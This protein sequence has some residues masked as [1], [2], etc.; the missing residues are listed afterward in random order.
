MNP[1]NIRIK[2]I[3]KL[4][5]VSKGTVD[6]VLHKRGRVSQEAYQRVMQVLEEIDYKPNLIA[7]T[8][9]SSKNYRI[10]ALLPNPASDEYWAQTKEGIHQAEAEWVHYNVTI[11]VSVFD[12]Y[13]K[14]SFTEKAIAAMDSKPDG[15]ITAP[16]FYDEAIVFFKALK[17]EGIPYVFFNTN[18]PEVEPLSF[19]GQDS[20]HSGK[21]GAELMFL[22]QHEGGRLAVL[23]L[24]EDIHNS[25]HLLEKERGFREYFKQRNNLSFDIKELSLRPNEPGFEENIRCLLN[26][27]LL[28]G[29]FVS[30][31]KGT[32]VVAALLEK[33]GKHNIRLIGYDILDDNL[34]YLRKG[35]IDFLINQ[36]P[37]RQAFL[38]I[39]HLANHLIFKKDAPERDLFPLEVITQQN[40]DSYLQSGIH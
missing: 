7:R 9:S 4:A 25:V 27:P 12:Q 30:T 2:D 6:R 21:V 39:S 8:L 34:K 24:D 36:N 20:F 1:K 40:L 16:I 23:H 14:E 29:I 10:V 15:I 37:K 28:K 33:N 5:G 3:A 11:D 26:D 38:S 35:T 31:S 13:N 19:I 17:H 22:G 32:S 18:I